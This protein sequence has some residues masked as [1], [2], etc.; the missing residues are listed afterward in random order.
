MVMKDADN[1]EKHICGDCIEVIA[2]MRETIKEVEGETFIDNNHGFVSE[3][4]ISGL[5][6]IDIKKFLDEYIVGQEYA[7]KVLSVAVYN[8][9]KRGIL[10][11]KGIRKSNV[12]LMGPTGS[13][14][15]YMVETLAKILNVPV[16]ITA[17][18][19]LTE[20][21]YIGDDVET[22]VKKL[23]DI[24]GGDVKK[25]ERGIIFI[26]EIDK[27][28]GK[29]SETEKKVGGK[30]V[31][32]ALLPLLEGTIVSV[33]KSGDS[34]DISGMGCKVNVDTSGILFIC[35]GAF[36]EI[37]EI[38]KKRMI[39]KSSIG[40]N[41][42]IKEDIDRF[43]ILLNVQNEDLY[44]FGLIPEFVGRLPII[45]PLENMTVEM[46]KRILAEPKDSIVSQYQR[47]FK[48]DGVDLIFDEDALVAIAERAIKKGT[49]ARSL[50]GILE[51]L[52][53][54]LMYECPSLYHIEKIHI[55]KEFVDGHEEPYMV[56]ENNLMHAKGL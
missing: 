26:D 10:N 6:P 48:F 15:T 11:D 37:E 3:I 21:G 33:N 18:T 47:L 56:K 45:A 5:K 50:R 42:Q 8:H 12:L 55:T 44:E 34:R 20:A 39:K 43:N 31:Q 14:K 28:S 25:A 22:V 40:F 52:L 54:D 1:N 4:N 51:E 32:Q 29:S 53:L 2:C 27:L 9:Y 38:I 46:L 35:G 23:L 7:K 41:A 30:G 13:G 16:A 49:G 19:T 24:A 36:P 17:A